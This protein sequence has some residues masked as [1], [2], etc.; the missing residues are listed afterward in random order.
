MLSIQCLDVCKSASCCHKALLHRS[1]GFLQWLL[2]S[3]SYLPP[4][5][6]SSFVVIPEWFTKDRDLLISLSSWNTVVFPLPLEW[7]PWTNFWDCSYTAL[8]YDF[9]NSYSLLVCLLQAVYWASL[10]LV[11]SSQRAYSLAPELLPGSTAFRLPKVALLS[12]SMLITSL[13]LFLLCVTARLLM[14][15]KWNTGASRLFCQFL[16]SSLSSLGLFLPWE[17]RW[18]CALHPHQVR[19]ATGPHRGDAWHLPKLIPLFCTLKFEV[20]KEQ[21]VGTLAWCLFER[22]ELFDPSP[23]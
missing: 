2:N 21:H 3:T 11:F 6:L 22:T 13:G 1:S 7:S 9:M 15:I 16:P 17:E 10:P 8:A 14:S 20:V 4:S 18:S 23:A 19:P 12:G 5:S